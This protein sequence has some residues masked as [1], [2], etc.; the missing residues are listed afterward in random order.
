MSD[1]ESSLSSK[2]WSF[3]SSP[4]YQWRTHPWLAPS[5][6]A[7]RSSGSF[8][9]LEARE[10][11]S[12]SDMTINVVYLSDL[13]SRVSAT[14]FSSGMNNILL[15]QWLLLVSRTSPTF[16]RLASRDRSAGW[17]ESPSSV[18][19]YSP[20]ICFTQ[21]CKE[22]SY[23]GFS[24]MFGFYWPWAGGPLQRLIFS[25]MYGR[26]R[27]WPVVWAPFVFACPMG[28]LDSTSSITQFRWL[29][30]SSWLRITP[31]KCS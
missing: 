26:G 18:S 8:I 25:R 3:T 20:C 28:W 29:A 16:V 24:S 10:L 9:S 19:T 5:L 14:P 23:P 11:R 22:F 4:G 12:K 27:V 30:R 13:S 15:L 17:R 7:S 21:G 6:N 31:R 2:E 1:P